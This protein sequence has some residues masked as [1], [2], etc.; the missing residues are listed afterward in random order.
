MAGKAFSKQL[1]VN[2]KTVLSSQIFD[3]ELYKSIDL[4]LSISTHFISSSVKDV[5]LGLQLQHVFFTA[6]G[7]KLVADSW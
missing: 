2:K 5:L 1:F 4:S 3:L 6:G 7:G